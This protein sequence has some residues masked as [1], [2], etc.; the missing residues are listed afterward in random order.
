MTSVLKE[1]QRREGGNKT[2]EMEIGVMWPQVKECL[3]P[4]E[5]KEAKNRFSLS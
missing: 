2:M 4:P 1:K 5:A 3:Q